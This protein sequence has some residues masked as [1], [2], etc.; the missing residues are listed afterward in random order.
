MMEYHLRWR[1]TDGPP[2][3]AVLHSVAHPSLRARLRA[4]AAGLVAVCRTVGFWLAVGLPVAYLPALVTTRGLLP[5]LLALHAAAIALGHDHR[6]GGRR[7]PDR[8]RDSE[9]DRTA[10]PAD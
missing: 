3:I 7:S 2:P 8:D 4:V 6:P 10:R 5:V 9:A 1:M